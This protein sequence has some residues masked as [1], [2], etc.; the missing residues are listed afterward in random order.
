VK[1]GD[2][3]QAKLSKGGGD[4]SESSSA[5]K[6]EVVTEGG[7]TAKHLYARTSIEERIA[8]C[9]VAVLA[10]RA[11]RPVGITL[12]ELNGYLAACGMQQLNEYNDW[13]GL[14]Q[15]KWEFRHGWDLGGLSSWLH[16]GAG[17]CR[18]HFAA[19][20]ETT[21][22]IGQHER[23]SSS[24]PLLNRFWLLE[25]PGQFCKHSKLAAHNLEGT[26]R[27]DP[28]CQ[29]ATTSTPSVLPTSCAISGRAKA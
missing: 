2:E 28:N 5:H 21:N 25:L 14:M 10:I 23:G 11:A 1:V 17:R 8:M 9:T 4:M 22:G 20:D 19:R 3:K 13:I 6:Y 26:W 12:Q 18:K 27:P 29:W 16:Q 7:P 15:H 24:L